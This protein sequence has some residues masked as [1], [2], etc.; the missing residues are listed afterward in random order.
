LLWGLRSS[1]DP[2]PENRSDEH[3]PATAISPRI[4]VSKNSFR[5][6]FE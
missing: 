2:S 3:E 6:S 1:D 5:E 4:Q